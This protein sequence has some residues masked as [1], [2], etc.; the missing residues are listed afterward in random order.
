MIHELRL[1]P[2]SLL[3][4]SSAAY[5]AELSI[6]GTTDKDVAIYKPG[7]KIEFT[8][9]VFDG[10]TPVAGTKLKWTRT[11]DDGKTA[12]GEGMAA[13]DGLKITTSLDKPGFVRLLVYAFGEDGKNAQGFVGGW[14]ANKNGNIFFDGGACVEPEHLQSVAEPKDFDEFWTATKSKLATVPLKADLKELASPTR[15]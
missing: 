9:R 12:Q 11:G 5:C 13:A 15:R 6:R 4:M 8:L 7:E 10:E 14:G 3:L 2:L 1:L